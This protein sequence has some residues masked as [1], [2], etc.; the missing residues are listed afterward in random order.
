LATVTPCAGNGVIVFLGTAAAFRAFTV[1]API[2]RDGDEAVGCEFA[3]QQQHALLAATR[4]VQGDDSGSPPAGTLRFHQNARHPLLRVRGK[5]EVK[6]N[7]AVR[8]RQ[9]INLWRESNARALNE[10]QEI[11]TR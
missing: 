10:L 4:A 2:N 6:L 8:R 1:I 9:F 11:R 3:T 5:R 7:D